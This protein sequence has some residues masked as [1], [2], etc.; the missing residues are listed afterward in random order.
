M[1]VVFEGNELL[2]DGSAKTAEARESRRRRVAKTHHLILFPIPIEQRGSLEQVWNMEAAIDGIFV[3]GHPYICTSLHTLTFL[4]GTQHKDTQ[5]SGL[6]LDV[7]S[8]SR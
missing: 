2:R 3:G 8:L 1:K 5:N 7:S 4:S 6:E